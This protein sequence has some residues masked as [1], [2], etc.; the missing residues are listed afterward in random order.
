MLQPC[1]M[2]HTLFSS[3]STSLILSCHSSVL[4]FLV[5]WCLGAAWWAAYSLYSSLPTTSPIITNKQISCSCYNGIHFLRVCML[6]N[7]F[8]VFSTILLFISYLVLPLQCCVSV[9]LHST[10]LSTVNCNLFLHTVRINTSFLS[11]VLFLL[12]FCL[13][14]VF[15]AL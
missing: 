12:Y 8:L 1:Q 3:P 2:L 9:K 6:L 13:L 15:L 7:N 11:L 4:P 5:F 14:S 10:V